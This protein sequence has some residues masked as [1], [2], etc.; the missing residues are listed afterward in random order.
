MTTERETLV[1]ICDTLIPALE[2]LPDEDPRLMGLSASHMNLAAIVEQAL[3]GTLDDDGRTELRQF[4]RMLEEPAFNGVTAGVWGMFS[5][6]T[7]EA[8]TRLLYAF[9]THRLPPVR[10]AFAGLSRLVLS[11]FYS[12]DLPEAPPNPTHAVLGYERSPQPVRHEDAPIELLSVDDRPIS[13]DVLIVGS[14]AGGGVAAA[15]LAKAGYDVLVVE[16][17]DRFTTHDFDGREFMAQQRLYEQQGA[18]TSADGSILL[19]AGSTLGGGTAVSWAGGLR[20]PAEVLEEWERTYGFD[21]V[22]GP[23][24]QRSLDAVSERLGLDPAREDAPSVN[25][26]V[27]EAGLRTLEYGV[28]RIPRMAGHCAGDCGACHFGCPTGAKRTTA[29]TFLQDAHDRG[30]RVLVRAHVERINQR[31]GEACG[32][33]LRVDRGDGRRRDIEVTCKAVVVAAGAVNTPALLLRSGLSNP[34]IGRNLHLHPT[35]ATAGV[36]PQ[37]IRAWQGAPMTRLSSQFANLDGRGYGVRLMNAP[38]HPGML[39]FAT[40]WQSGRAHKRRMQ[41]G[42]ATANI[43]AITRDRDGG[44]VTLDRSG[45]PRVGY[46]L[47]SHDA[48]HVMVGMQEAMRVHLAAGALEVRAPLANAPTYRPEQGGSFNEFLRGVE[49]A[50]LRPNGFPLFSA[51]QMSSSRIAGS[52]KL[53]A[54]NPHGESWELKHLFVLDGSALP[55]SSG[56]NPMLTILGVSHFLSQRIAA[57]L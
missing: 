14:G 6:L 30:A 25:T 44:R 11:L 16:K 47:S 32:A 17:G 57:L 35:V 10:R 27:F 49:Q 38:A 42:E 8:R 45:R 2:A 1:A 22:C 9:S 33:L 55:T 12:L 23:E 41:R 50:G 52:P 43:I 28:T 5:G 40:P 4:L 34:N 39:S 18:L 54:V 37:P 46:T 3:S 19:L 26:Q 20:T 51:H 29:R 53:G 36:F 15:V 7:L 56:V 24:Y 48:K 21:G 31:A 13:C